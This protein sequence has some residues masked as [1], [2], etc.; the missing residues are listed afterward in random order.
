MFRLLRQKVAEWE[1]K[2]VLELTLQH[3]IFHSFVHKYSVLDQIRSIN[4]NRISRTYHRK[5][6]PLDTEKR[7]FY[8]LGNRCAF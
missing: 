5:H 2:Q 4:P 3:F 8:D 6:Y 1:I 7:T